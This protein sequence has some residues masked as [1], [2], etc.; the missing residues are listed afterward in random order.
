MGPCSCRRGWCSL[1]TKEE[2]KKIQK[3]ASCNQ[4]GQMA[5]GR[6]SERGE[7]L[8]TQNRC[9]QDQCGAEVIHFLRQGDNLH[10]VLS[11]TVL[12]PECW[13]EIISFVLLKAY[14]DCNL[15]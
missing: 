6:P 7:V 14:Q 12:L 13:Y 4:E 15:I 5:I 10:L 3:I 11:P 9:W 8:Y 2:N 1:N